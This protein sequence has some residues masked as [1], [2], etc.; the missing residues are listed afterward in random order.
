MLVLSRRR[1]E[2][3]II[4]NDVKVIILEVLAHRVKLGFQAPRDV[5]VHREEVWIELQA[6]DRSQIAGREVRAP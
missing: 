1:G 3:V 2:S 5:A 6:A 4:G